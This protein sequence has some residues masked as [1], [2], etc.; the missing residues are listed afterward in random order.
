MSFDS[1]CV[2]VGSL[3]LVWFHLISLDFMLCH[4]IS[5][6]FTRVHLTS[7]DFIRF[8]LI[9]LDF[10]WFHL[11]SLDF[12]L[13]HLVLLQLTGTHWKSLNSLE[14]TRHHWTHWNSLK[15]TALSQGKRERLVWEKEKEKG[16]PGCFRR[17][18]TLQP[19]RKHARTNE[20]KRF[21]GWCHTPNLW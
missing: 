4:L 19:D 21:P 16:G 14:L 17:N 8:H 9:L 10:T 6:E 3:S 18:S 20:T 15:F 7:L 1:T 13:F 12:T 5:L 2:S 11:I